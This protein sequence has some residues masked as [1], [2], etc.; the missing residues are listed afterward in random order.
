MRHVNL[1]SSMKSVRCSS[2]LFDELCKLNLLFT[3][4]TNLDIHVSTDVENVF[5]DATNKGG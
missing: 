4:F 5:Q 3:F 1:F 2:F